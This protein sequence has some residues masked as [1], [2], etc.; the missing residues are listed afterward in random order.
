M[1][2][3]GK[4]SLCETLASKTDTEGKGKVIDIFCSRDNEGLSWCRHDQFKNSVLLLHGDSVRISSQWDEQRISELKLQDIVSHKTI[5]SVPAFYANLREEWNAIDKITRLLWKRTHWTDVWTVAIR[6]GTS[7]LYSRLGLGENQ[8]QAKASFVY[9]I[10]EFR[11]C[12]CALVMDIIR[13]YGLDT[14][15]RTIANYIFIKAHG[16]D[17]LPKDLEWL[18]RYYDLFK[19]I[20]RMQPWA[21]IMLTRKGGVAHGTFQYPYWHKE[22]HEDIL[23]KLD[24]DIDVQGIVNYG[25]KGY[26]TVSDFDHVHTIKARIVLN[27]KGKKTGLTALSKGGTFKC[28]DEQITLEPRSSRTI[29]AL[30]E[31]HNK[32][33]QNQGYCQICHRLQEV[34]LERLLV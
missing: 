16:I 14:E 5:I 12:G 23:K 34:K 11:H 20:M 9:A 19:D 18:Y 30:V 22:E 32:D 8:A 29:W 31:N 25:E 27:G 33:V 13:Y 10:K 6:E 7:L 3:S 2:E 21:F 17:G 4:S 1:P 26:K 15:V 28:Q 24:I